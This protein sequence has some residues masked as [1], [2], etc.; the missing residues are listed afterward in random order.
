[1]LFVSWSMW[2]TTVFCLHVFISPFGIGSLE[3]K[4]FCHP[5]T[6]V[7][8]DSLVEGLTVQGTLCFCGRDG[9]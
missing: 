9:V 8:D 6:M 5:P 7:E 3:V 1:M 4:W 2:L